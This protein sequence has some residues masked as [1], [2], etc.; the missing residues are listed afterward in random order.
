MTC[1]TGGAQ[2][3]RVACCR[4]SNLDRTALTAAEHGAGFTVSLNAGGSERAAKRPAREDDTGFDLAAAADD[5]DDDDDEEEDA[6]DFKN[7]LE[8]L[9]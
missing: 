5:D 3:K 2:A 4:R 9:F 6:C 1:T 7:R 8:P